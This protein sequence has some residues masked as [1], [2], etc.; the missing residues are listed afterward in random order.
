[1]TGPSEHITAWADR[2]EAACA[3]LPN[4]PLRSAKV[5][6]YARTASTQDAAWRHR[7]LDGAAI[8]VASEQTAGRGQRGRRWDDGRA[9]TL[10][11]SFA[12]PTPLQDVALSARVGLAALDTCREAAPGADIRIKWPNDI[13]VRDQSGDRKLAG[14][15]IE[16]RDGWAVVGVGINACQ[17]S[18][19]FERA[20]LPTACSLGM[21]NSATDRVS[22][23]VGLT[24]AMSRWLSANDAEVREHWDRHDAM[25]DRTHQF[26]LDREV[27][28]GT[29]TRVDPLH[30]ITVRCGGVDRALP[31][32]RTTTQKPE[33]L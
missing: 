23:A 6:V 11:I 20:G 19:D 17:A 29:V 12:W 18:M 21:L 27:I 7:R 10:P 24:G 28:V 31:V 33:A 15:L 22:L 2:L 3:A 14:V 16:R 32:D 30:A 5:F 1:V 4:G 9:M 26:V 13:V 8:A 25:K